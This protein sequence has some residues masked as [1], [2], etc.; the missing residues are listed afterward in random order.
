MIIIIIII[1]FAKNILYIYIYMVTICLKIFK[2]NKIKER[3][4][5][6]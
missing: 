5:G 4:S 6:Q 1:T 2:K 3:S